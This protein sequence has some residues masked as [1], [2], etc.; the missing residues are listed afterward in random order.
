MSVAVKK[1][2][3]SLATWVGHVSPRK[4]WLLWRAMEWY[5]F[6]ADRLA[7]WDFYINE[8]FR[9]PTFHQ[10]NNERICILHIITYQILECPEHWY[11]GRQVGNPDIL[12][13]RFVKTASFWHPGRIAFPFFWGY[14]V[15]PLE[16]A[17]DG[18]SVQNEEFHFGNSLDTAAGTG[19]SGGCLVL[20]ISR[21][22]RLVPEV[23]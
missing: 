4:P 8:S 2:F 7:V 14:S 15:Y 6:C 9:L 18:R 12:G 1:M 20:I 23:I 19:D 13:H 11:L 16:P 21:I 10:L 17:R 22:T 3:S 5:F